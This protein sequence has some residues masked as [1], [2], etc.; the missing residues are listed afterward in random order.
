MEVT[1]FSRP[2]NVRVAPLTTWTGAFSP[3]VLGSISTDAMY[4]WI[5]PYDWS[6][7]HSCET[8]GP[9]PQ[10]YAS[11]RLPS[12]PPDGAVRATRPI[13]HVAKRDEVDR[14]VAIEAQT[15]HLAHFVL[16]SF[17]AAVGPGVV[18]GHAADDVGVRHLERCVDLVDPDT[19]GI[20]LQVHVHD[21]VARYRGHHHAVG[22]RVDGYRHDRVG[23]EGRVVLI[24]AHAQ[25][26]HVDLVPV[27]ELVCDRARRGLDGL[28]HLSDRVD[29]VAGGRGHEVVEPLVRERGAKDDRED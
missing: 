7:A 21:Q 4:R 22:R 5:M 26:Q 28:H 29:V 11:S 24:S 19:T 23:Q 16:G 18:R 3:S 6:S 8:A 27:L 20:A 2:G 10:L 12:A 25:Q 1:R 13:E 14:D 17:A 15:G 9:M